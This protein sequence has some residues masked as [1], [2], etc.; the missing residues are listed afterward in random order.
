M[1]E[2][3]LKTAE[4]DGLNEVCLIQIDESLVIEKSVNY[5]STLCFP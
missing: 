1:I 4:P 3:I 5:D 2:G